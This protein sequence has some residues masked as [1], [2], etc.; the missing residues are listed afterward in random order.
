MHAKL[1]SLTQP[2][3]PE[4]VDKQFSAEDLL[5]YVARVSNPQNQLNQE[6]GARLLRYCIEHKHW[7]IFETASMTMEVQTSRMVAAQLLRHRSFTFQEFS[8]RYSTVKGDAV[9]PVELRWKAEGGNR[10]GSGGVVPAHNHGQ[11]LAKLALDTAFSAYDE[12]IKGGVS[13]ETARQV[14]PLATSTTMYVTGNVRSWIHYLHQ[15]LDSHS[16]KEHRLLAQEMQ[17]VFVE[18]F[19]VT[20]EAL[21][22]NV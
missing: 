2:V 4:L 7:S 15:R 11:W 22:W 16:Q 20:A 13:P 19:P 8:Q 17:K 12:L 6:T 21:K 1:I 3:L 5:I 10:Q 14:L 18:H 9:E